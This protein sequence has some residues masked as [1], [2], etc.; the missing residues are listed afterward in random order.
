MP[1]ANGGQKKTAVSNLSA[2][3]GGVPPPTV[4]ALFMVMPPFPGGAWATLPT[5]LSRQKVLRKVEPGVWA[6]K[7]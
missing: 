5:A 7:G 1:S 2:G 4:V 6:Y 3:H